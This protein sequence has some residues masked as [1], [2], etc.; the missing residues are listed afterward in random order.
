[1]RVRY[2]VSAPAGEDA[3]LGFAIQ[4]V[5]FTHQIDPRQKASRPAV[6]SG[7]Y[8]GI[9]RIKGLHGK[10]KPKAEIDIPKMNHGSEFPA[11]DL[12]R[13]AVTQLLEQL[14]PQVQED[15]RLDERK[16]AVENATGER[17]TVWVQTQTH[18]AKGDKTKWE[19]E[20]G[21][22][23]QTGQAF[24]FTLAPQE[25]Y[26][27]I[28][29][30]RREAISGVAARIS[31][32]S[33]SGRIWTG[34]Q[35]QNV[36]L[37]D[38]F[39]ENDGRHYYASTMET[40]VYRL[41]NAGKPAK[42][43]TRAVRVTN[44]TDHAVVVN[45]QAYYLDVT[46]GWI[47]ADA[48]PARIEPGR[49]LTLE[50]TDGEL[51]HGA[52]ARLWAQDAGGMRSRWV[53]YRSSAAEQVAAGGYEATKIDDF[54]YIL[55]SPGAASKNQP[56]KSGAQA[57]TAIT[58]H[59]PADEVWTSDFQ[60]KTVE[61]ARK[62]ITSIGLKVSTDKDAVAG[63]RVTKQSP[64]RGWLPAGAEVRLTATAS[65]PP[66]STEAVV[67]PPVVGEPLAQA[68]KRLQAAGLIAGITNDPEHE[69][70]KKQTPS[71]GAKV[72]PGTAISLIFVSVGDKAATAADKAAAKRKEEAAATLAWEAA[73]KR[74][75]EEAEKAA[76]KRASG[77][78]GGQEQEH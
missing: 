45:A 78:S 62:D 56:V 34:N 75:Q 29:T 28:R 31:A 4:V 50:R 47:W 59:L 51:L 20:P 13:Q 26:A 10:G 33:E 53:K 72:P 71:E 40:F 66:A 27:L 42:F 76:S 11:D 9:V 41:G 6:Q 49:T 35:K 65:R 1:M 57:Q 77:C 25:T 43:V 48:R 12:L 60:G 19:W 69:V 61:E 44:R 55:E 16:L 70:V 3:A 32:Q 7:V 22:V 58:L 36:W 5:G 24:K 15:G 54:D 2:C 17:V 21:L 30:D 8:R 23:G 14:L 37:V 52:K 39:E 46:A 74:F 64:A 67:V 73:A 68:T 18:P 63:A 38:D